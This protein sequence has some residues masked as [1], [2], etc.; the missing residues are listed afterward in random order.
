MPTKERNSNRPKWKQIEVFPQPEPN[1]GVSQTVP[2]Q[3][4]S[5]KEIMQ[6]H[7]RGLAI[8]QKIPLYHDDEQLATES[9]RDISTMDISEVHNEMQ[10]INQR[11]E[12]KEKQKKENQKKKQQEES[13]KREQEQR[14]KWRKE[15]DEEKNQSQSKQ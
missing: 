7:S 5:I 8:D 1:N 9:G 2:D 10:E 4:M 12:E 6:R 3:T 14:D 11:L 13:A 15:W